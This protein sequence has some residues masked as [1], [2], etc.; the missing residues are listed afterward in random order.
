MSRVVVICRH[1]QQ[2]DNLLDGLLSRGVRAVRVGRPDATRPELLA[3]SVDALATEA[4]KAAS[5]RGEDARI[6]RDNAKNRAL[7]EA[8]VCVCGEALALFVS[9]RRRERSRETRGG[10]AVHTLGVARVVRLSSEASRHQ[11]VVSKTL[12]LRREPVMKKNAIRNAI[13]TPSKRKRSRDARGGKVL[14]ATCVGAGAAALEKYR[15][16]AVLV[17]EA[18]QAT[19]LAT[20]VHPNTV[21]S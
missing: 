9:A 21:T 12:T 17:D 15:F 16:S 20:L 3:H 11:Q 1:R 10:D 18:A 2:V 14:C 7:A 4:A 8:E 19:E 13:K 6:A 5:A